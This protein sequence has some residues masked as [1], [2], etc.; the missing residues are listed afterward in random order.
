MNGKFKILQVEDV[1]TEAEL[2]L[3]ELK[4]AGIRCES[5]RV[6][7]RI[8][9]QRE[10]AD[11]QPDIILSDFS[12]PHFDGMEALDIAARDYPDIPFIFVSGTLGE[13]YAV[14]ALK[15][16]ATDYVLKTN[17]IRLPAAVERAIDEA[18]KRRERQMV[19]RE[20]RESEER[21]R[22]LAENIR[23]VFWMYATDT[24]AS[25]YVSPAF[26]Q[27]WQRPIGNVRQV[28]QNWMDS[29]YQEDRS[30]VLGSLDQMATGNA[31][32]DLEYRIVRPDGSLHWI[33]DR[34]FPVRDA[35]GQ[36]YRVVGIAED[37]NERKHAEQR[38]REN[39]AGLRRGQLMAKLAHIITGLDGVFET[40]SDTLPQLIGLEP[41]KVPKSTREWLRLLH[42]ED[43]EL[44]RQKSIEAAVTGTRVDVEYR[45]KHAH[46][47]WIH[48]QQVIEPLE[49]L[50]YANAT[51]Q[52]F[53]TLQDVTERKQSEQ[54]IKRLNRVYA[55]LSSINSA[56]VRIR[57]RRELFQET[58]RI[59][60]EEGGFSVGWIATF[61]P[62]NGKL[63]PI[64]QAGLP[65]DFVARAESP[66]HPG[67]LI[68]SGTSEVALREKRP[69]FDN[70]IERDP[71]VELEPDA[72]S[73]RRAAI[74]RGAKSVIA[75]PLFVDGETF[76]IL[77]LYSPERE[78]FDDEEIKLLSELAG[79]VSFAVEYI[80][81]EEKLNYLA[82]YD[83]LTGLP[84]VALF[85]DRLTQF[86]QGAKRSKGSVA[87]ILINL[88]RFRHLNDTLGRHAGD[89][90]LKIVG[91]RLAK[92]FSEPFSL[93]RISADS[94]AIAVADIKRED[95]LAN[96]LQDRVFV[97]LGQPCE[98]GGSEI[99]VSAKAGIALYPGDGTD[100]ETLFRNAEAA[101]KQAKSS[102]E[103][104]L[105]YAR[106]MNAHI[107]EKLAL[108]N[109][110]RQAL[111]REEF[112]LHY[113]PKMNVTDGRICGMEALIRWNDP[114]TGL[115]PPLKFIALLEETG[116]I[117][118]VGAW[119]LGQAVSDYRQLSAK[120]IACPR[121]AVNVSPLQ[122]RQKDF[123]SSVA[124]AM[125][126]GGER[127]D[128][129]DLEITESVIMENIESNISLLRAVRAMNVN[130]AIDDFGTGY[131][132]LAY[133][134]KLPVNTLKI[135]RSF[136]LAMGHSAE[137]RNIVSTIISLAH[138]LDL[139]VVAEGVE[140][141][142]QLILLRRLQC[143]EMQEYLFS[144]PIPIEQ[145]EPMLRRL[146]S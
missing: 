80:D 26:E 139:K 91:D 113:Q 2:A 36:I 54:K 83:A 121:I 44:F 130:I 132:S 79:D 112:V 75:L 21:F 50:P 125:E 53:C 48:V 104:Y 29:I 7:T 110:L 100:A 137:D 114:E 51:K 41:D 119:A 92:A 15:N 45:M 94:F 124:A 127:T 116:L 143:D 5:R 103:N 10:L 115:V 66:E 141:E 57:D 52:W 134:A 105:F 117:I 118:Q 6:E 81:K 30:R 20:L 102:G 25:L 126:S 42:P 88:D 16:G 93:A 78:F 67:E 95:D 111:E 69:A 82:Y 37:V 59:I 24:G 120:G 8:D 101:L 123:A 65:E 32:F 38:L 64:A 39:E 142:E 35:Q 131:S 58:C 34:G 60:V 70:D 140:T 135:D 68:P 56:I 145:I 109:K 31:Q 99:R 72:K 14:R 76:G 87:A 1:R 49:N 97:I 85:R 43:R 77:T 62:L 71:G 84:N 107:A 138:S 23:E 86:I 11:F 128:G 89:T 4:R 47:G 33:H 13:E 63:V 122:L 27:I 136:I 19:E 73:V 106:E 22:Q 17:L 96:L 98:L 61:N 46:G 129:L 74:R 133:I 146:S 108:E 55:M 12:M 40:W 18:Q 28:H 3:R 9:F 144:A 90:L